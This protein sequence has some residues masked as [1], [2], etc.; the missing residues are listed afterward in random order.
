MEEE[1]EKRRKVEQELQETN[2]L[3]SKQREESNLLNIK[4]EDT[5]LRYQT[6]VNALKE[7]HRRESELRSE[8]QNN[9]SMLEQKVLMLTEQFNAES[10]AKQAEI[11]ILDFATFF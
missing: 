6:D 11:G 7:Q 5:L 2:S 10:K 4:L 3:L 1:T 9:K 8:T